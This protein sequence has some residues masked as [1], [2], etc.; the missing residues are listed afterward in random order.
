MIP[1]ANRANSASRE[2]NPNLEPLSRRTA[3]SVVRR[4]QRGVVEGHDD[5]RAEGERG[6]AECGV[7]R[8]EDG[9]RPPAAFAAAAVREE[10]RGAVDDVRELVGDALEKRRSREGAGAAAERVD[11]QEALEGVAR[12]R[13]APD[14]V[15]DAVREGGGAVVRDRE[16]AARADARAVAHDAVGAEQPAEGAAGDGVHRAR[17]EVAQHRAGTWRPRLPSRKKTARGGGGG[18]GGEERGGRRGRRARARARRRLRNPAA[19]DVANA[20]RDA[21]SGSRRNPEGR[22]PSSSA[23][24]AEEPSAELVPG[25]PDAR[26]DDLAHPKCAATARRGREGAR[27]RTRESWPNDET[28]KIFSWEK[29]NQIHEKKPSKEG[30][31]RSRQTSSPPP[32]AA[33]SSSPRARSRTHIA[34][35]SLRSIARSSA[36]SS[37]PPRSSSRAPS[38]HPPRH[39][40]R[41]SLARL[42]GLPH[43]Q[44]VALE[45]VAAGVPAGVEGRAG[46]GLDP[47]LRATR[48]RGPDESNENAKGENAK[49]GVPADPDADADSGTS[50]TRRLPP[51]PRDVQ[52]SR[53]RVPPGAPTRTIPA[54]RED[55]APAAAVPAASPRSRRSAARAA[56]SPRARSGAAA[57]R[58]PV[59]PSPPPPPPPWPPPPSPPASP[60]PPWLSAN[61]R[62]RASQRGALLVRLATSLLR[63]QSCVCFAAFAVVVAAAMRQ[64]TARPCART[65]RRTA[66]SPFPSREVGSPP[67]R[68]AAPEG[69]ARDAALHVRVPP[70]AESRGARRRTSSASA[71]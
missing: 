3:F 61:A 46:L 40:A 25:A 71:R 42:P 34:R 62:L 30:S 43:L 48:R 54:R 12:L 2:A 66:R 47:T 69:G 11:E 35:S 55:A 14:G 59:A 52:K 18:G 21:S 44:D 16:V 50:A 68:A 17:L 27:A 28:T 37:R 4:S 39:R 7:E 33:S 22:T 60:P 8:L 10:R 70:R 64:P 58:A 29:H 53:R 63:L 65:S 38:S 57:R 31:V 49:E 9:V 1:H 23:E 26:G 32:N 56:P 15:H 19:L 20:P 24:L 5:V 51:P 6:D 45:L 13:L 36:T 67:G 41:P